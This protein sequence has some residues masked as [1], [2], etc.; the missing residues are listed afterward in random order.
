MSLEPL[1][2]LGTRERRMFKAFS[3]LESSS[4]AVRIRTSGMGDE[5]PYL[6]GKRLGMGSDRRR[7]AIVGVTHDI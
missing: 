3:G 4:C 6:A 7:G 5:L 2:G 1:V